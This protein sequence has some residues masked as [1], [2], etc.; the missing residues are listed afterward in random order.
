M[1]VYAQQEYKLQ[2]KR[3]LAIECTFNICG[4][5]YALLWIQVCLFLVPALGFFA[6]VCLK[7]EVEVLLFLV[8]LLLVV[9]V[10]PV[11]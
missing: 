11:K 10:L 6:F 1:S 2:K 7:G 4:D 3:K 5:T 8:L 9:L